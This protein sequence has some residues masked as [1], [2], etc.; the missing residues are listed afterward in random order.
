MVLVAI[1]LA[2]HAC[3]TEKLE[4]PKVTRIHRGRRFKAGT[5][6]LLLSLGIGHFSVYACFSAVVG[7]SASASLHGKADV[8]S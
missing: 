8:E 2:C 5:Q 4:F 1:D 3:E 6:G 7:A